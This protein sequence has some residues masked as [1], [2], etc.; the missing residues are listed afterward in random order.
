MERPSFIRHWTELEN[1]HSGHYPGDTELMAITAPLGAKL[2]LERIAV[3]HVRLLP[4]RRTSYPHAESLEEEFIFVLEGTPDVWVDGH[5]HRLSP[6]ESVAFVP[7]TGICHTF[8]N[9][10]DDEV[11]LLVIGDRPIDANRVRYPKN[12]AHEATRKDRWVDW[13][14]RELGPHD[15]KP[16]RQR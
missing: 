3:N 12:E 14:A 1:E 6:G 16:D 2:G 13:P 4:G 15:G 10:T 9:N 7:G 5:L 8:I 11:K